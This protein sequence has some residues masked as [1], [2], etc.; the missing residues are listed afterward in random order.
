MRQKPIERLCNSC[1]IKCSIPLTASEKD[2]LSTALTNNDNHPNN[3]A[4]CRMALLTAEWRRIIQEGVNA[5]T[6]REREFA[7]WCKQ[8]GG[9]YCAWGLEWPK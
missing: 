2:R 8:V 9:E 5:R 7:A 6:A 3:H 4:S 1:D